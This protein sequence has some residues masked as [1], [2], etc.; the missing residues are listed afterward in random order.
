MSGS[1]SQRPFTKASGRLILQVERKDKVVQATWNKGI[2][3]AIQWQ[4]GQYVVRQRQSHGAKVWAQIRLRRSTQPWLQPTAQEKEVFNR[5]DFI[6]DENWGQRCL[7]DL[8]E[9]SPNRKILSTW[10]EDFLLQQEVSRDELTA[11]L[12]NKEVPWRRKRRLLQAITL[13]FPCSA[14]LHKIGV[15]TSD[16]CIACHKVSLRQGLGGEAIGKG[17]YGHIQSAACLATKEAVTAAHNKCLNELIDAI[18]KHKKKK[19]S[20][21]FIKEDT[22]VSFKTA[23]QN[24]ELQTICT[25]QQIEQAAV[26]EYQ[27]LN[28]NPTV[29]Q[30]VSAVDVEQLWRRRPDRIAINRDKKIIYIIEFKR[31]IDLRPSY[32]TNAE[33][34]A[35][36]QH[37]WLT[38]T[39]SKAAAPMDWAVQTV[40]F[41]GGTM[42]SV[43]IDRFEQNLT[44]L[45]VKK[46]AWTKIRKMHARAL[47][48]AQDTVLRAYYN[49]V[50]ASHT[51]EVQHRHHV[52]ANVYV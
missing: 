21:T 33:D 32:Q 52:T 22:D 51:Q 2:Q 24:S 5:K 14:W 15:A 46:K 26:Q 25:A 27:A 48:E 13:S 20:I 11:W 16:K 47:L 18:I 50:Y 28:S 19:S 40:I 35:E 37:N 36:K 44:R 39:L 10:C 23:W 29:D 9:A 34:R 3:A 43:K 45:E 41:T 6:T 7:S 49:A 8:F 31:T 1:F 17:T 12:T 38:N 4:G 42:G 30:Q